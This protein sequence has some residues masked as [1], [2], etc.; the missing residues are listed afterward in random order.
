MGSSAK[1]T[2]NSI[3]KAATRRVT[4]PLAA[5]AL[6]DTGFVNP[7]EGTTRFTIDKNR[8][9]DKHSEI[10]PIARVFNIELDGSSNST[11]GFT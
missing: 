9:V 1:C 2:I 5:A 6:G 4:P 8:L 7:S 3:G 10:V 11:I